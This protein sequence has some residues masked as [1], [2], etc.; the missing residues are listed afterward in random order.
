MEIPMLHRT[1]KNSQESPRKITVL[2]ALETRLE[3]KL[4]DLEKEDQCVSAS[5]CQQ[6]A[7]ASQF[8]T[9]KLR[10]VKQ[11]IQNEVNSIAENK[12]QNQNQNQ[13]WIQNQNQNQNWIQ[14]QNQNQNWIQNQNQNRIQNMNQCKVES[15]F[16]LFS[17]DGFSFPLYR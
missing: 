6:I 8:L 2:Y 15:G 5:T 12:N 4:K 17:G 9:L 13:N 1:I 7:N 11:E 16:S 10:S 3:K 14:N